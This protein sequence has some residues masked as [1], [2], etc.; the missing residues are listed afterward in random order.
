L[1]NEIAPACPKTV[2]LLCKESHKSKWLNFLGPV[3]LVRRMMLTTLIS[4]ICFIAVSMLPQINFENIKSGIYV[5]CGTKLLIVMAFL[6]SSASLGAS[7]SNLF[8][9]NQYIVK[10]IYDP[11]YESSYWIRYVLGITAGIM[12]AVVIPVPD[13]AEARQAHLA[14]ASRPML[15]MLG[16]F[17]ASLVYCILFRM[18]YAVK[19]IFIGKQSDATERKLA[20]L[21]ISNDI[22][23]ENKKQQFVNK[24]LQLQAQINQK[25]SIKEINEEIQ[26]IISDM[27]T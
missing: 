1:S 15:A 9:A 14:V 12:L 2:W 20:D 4:L 27:T 7:F 24:L 21:Q 26:K 18:V 13:A 17:S 11:Q 19:S 6:L 5:L 16:G 10:N 22:E 8:Q 23:R 3:G 25:S